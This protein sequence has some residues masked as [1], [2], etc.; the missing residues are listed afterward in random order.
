MR[1]VKC[2]TVIL[3]STFSLLLKAQIPKEKESEGNCYQKYAVVFEKRGANDVED[4]WHNNVIISIRKGSKAECFNG[5]CFVNKGIVEQVFI[6][7][8][9]GNF[10]PVNKKYKGDEKGNVIPMTVVNG[11]SRTEITKDD[12]LINIM[13]IEKIKPK[14]KEYEKAPDPN[15][16]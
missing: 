9:D 6:K 7:F 5:K 13:F 4:G 15:F 11:I 8:N 16:D 3:F 14:K 10:E 1:T 2:L 12:E